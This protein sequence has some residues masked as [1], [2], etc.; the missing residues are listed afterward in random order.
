MRLRP[1]G[2]FSVGYEDYY[3]QS[4]ENDCAFQA[5]AAL[6]K[7]FKVD[8]CWIVERNSIVDDTAHG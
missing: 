8:T 4:K 5:F 2:G 7:F 1:D 3:D 6:V